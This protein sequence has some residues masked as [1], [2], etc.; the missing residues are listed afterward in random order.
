MKLTVDTS[1]EL[2]RRAEEVTGLRDVAVLIH[3]GLDALILKT[4]TAKL[5]AMGG[6][7]PKVKMLRR[8][9]PNQA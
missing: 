7:H 9:R 2:F 1:H 5:R 3:A 4:T 8:R 6:A